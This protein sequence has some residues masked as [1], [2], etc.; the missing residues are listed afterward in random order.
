MSLAFTFV[1][2]AVV[3][4]V[5][6]SMIFAIWRGFISETLSIFAW[7]AAAFATLYFGPFIAPIVSHLFSPSW[8]AWLVGYV[9]VFLFVLIPISYGSFRLSESVQRSSVGPL[10][11]TLGAIFGIA[12]GL[13]IVGGLYILF[14]LFVPVREHPAPLRDAKL[15]PLIQRSAEILISLAPVDTRTAAERR[16][17]VAPAHPQRAAS[18]RDKRPETRDTHKHAAKAYGAGDRQALD[19]LIEATGG[20]RNDKP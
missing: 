16:L 8:L 11:R 6:A 18:D 4:I 10:D 20:S 9:G 1:D 12:R 7:A 15:L 3:A 14:T 17:E 19:K 13:V 5:I 2:V